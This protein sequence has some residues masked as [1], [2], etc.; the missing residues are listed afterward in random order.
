M[1]MY[2]KVMNLA[3][4][5][6]TVGCVAVAS[7]SEN[8]IELSQE[9]LFA[10]QRINR[11]GGCLYFCFKR[12]F[13]WL[14]KQDAQVK[15]SKI[16]QCLESHPSNIN[17][18]LTYMSVADYIDKLI[19]PHF[20]QLDKAFAEKLEVEK[21]DIS[22][23]WAWFD[24]YFKQHGLIEPLRAYKTKLFKDDQE[25]IRLAMLRSLR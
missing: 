18:L 19:R 24:G 12:V 21:N 13:Q 2:K 17:D 9:T 11:D 25:R 20:E 6:V 22:R 3:L 15:P 23:T 14:G 1:V 8:K 5:C 10:M 4:V 7:E 16:L